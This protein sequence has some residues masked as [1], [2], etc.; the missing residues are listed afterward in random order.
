MCGA[1][2]QWAAANR[3]R[4]A[5]ALFVISDAGLVVGEEH[6]ADEI[7]PAANAGLLE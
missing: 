6:L 2:L 1:A 5:H 3:F 4:V 7:A